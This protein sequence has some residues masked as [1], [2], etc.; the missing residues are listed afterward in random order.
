MDWLNKYNGVIR[1]AKR[2]VE[3]TSSNGTKVEFMAAPFTKETVMLN[4]L[5]GTPMEE[6]CVVR[7]Y[8]D[9]FSEDLPGMPPDRDIECIIYFGPG[10]KPIS[11]RPYRMPANELAELK[12][13]IVELQE[14]GLNVLVHHHG[15]HPCS[16]LRRRMV[17]KGCVWSTDL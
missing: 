12:K 9:I 14:K 4:Q 2:S 16:S 5:K 15:E 8:P 3:L 10:T 11:K 17:R 6:I 13:L 7:D 1:C